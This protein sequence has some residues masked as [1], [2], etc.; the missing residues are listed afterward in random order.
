MVFCSSSVKHN[1]TIYHLS[2]LFE[3]VGNER[4]Q[5]CLVSR[6]K[7]S[8]RSVSSQRSSWVHKGQTNHLPGTDVFL[9]F[10][11]QNHHFIRR[12]WRFVS[13]QFYYRIA[14]VNSIGLWVN[15]VNS[16]LHRLPW[17]H[18]ECLVKFWFNTKRSRTSLHILHYDFP[19]AERV[20]NLQ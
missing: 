3:Q 12:V 1:G 6:A 14:E 20:L 19:P 8:D 9:H 7:K 13:N 18:K 16:W 17:W 4:F 2:D 15:F 10:L 5:R 11:A